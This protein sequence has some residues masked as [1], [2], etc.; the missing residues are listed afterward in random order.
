MSL[1]FDLVINCDLREG[2]PEQAI[3]V[4]RCLT[5]RDYQLNFKPEVLY[6]GQGD[7]WDYWTSDPHFLAL[8]PQQDVISNFR[9]VHRMTMPLEGNR[10]VYRYRLQYCGSC[11]HDDSF[12][13]LHMPFVYWLATIAYE[14]HLGYYGE[15][16]GGGL[17]VQQL[18]A[19]N[20]KLQ[21]S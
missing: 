5:E 4:I 3:E 17:G 19:K 7:L 12:Y 1:H 18:I 9:R 16:H 6:P 15:T 14:E 10:E 21:D 11:L 8:N 20:G 13:E 2:T